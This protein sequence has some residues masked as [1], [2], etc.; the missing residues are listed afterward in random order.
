M[1]KLSVSNYQANKPPPLLNIDLIGGKRLQS[2]RRGQVRKTSKKS[3]IESFRGYSLPPIDKS[4]FNTVKTLN[5]TLQ[6]QLSQYATNLKTVL[7]DYQVGMNNVKNCYSTCKSNYSGQ[8]SDIQTLEQQDNALD[9]Q[10]ACIAGCN[11]SKV[12]LWQT[13][14]AASYAGTDGTTDTFSSCAA[15][16]KDGPEYCRGF[17]P[18][19]YCCDEWDDYGYGYGCNGYYGDY[20]E[21]YLEGSC[22]CKNG[23]TKA[24][25]YCGHQPFTCN[26]VCQPGGKPYNPNAPPQSPPVPTPPP[27][28]GFPHG[29]YKNGPGMCSNIDSV[30]NNT[31][32]NCAVNAAASQKG[33]YWIPPSDVGSTAPNVDVG[34]YPDGLCNISSGTCSVGGGYFNCY[35]TNFIGGTSATN[36]IGPNCSTASSTVLGAVAYTYNANAPPSSGAP[37]SQNKPLC[38][39]AGTE[40]TCM[41]NWNGGTPVKCMG[42]GKVACAS[43]D[44]ANCFWGTCG[45]N[46]A[47]TAYPDRSNWRSGGSN[48]MII[49]CGTTGAWIRSDG[50]STCEILSGGN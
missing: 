19:N 39:T 38:E 31:L 9:N 24:T 25:V 14:P 49:N 8:N 2:K 3:V 26:E 4:E 6:G 36:N 28:G 20:G 48:P 11:L 32:S 12:Y 43:N 47:I 30:T 37:W 42:N 10:S 18:T 41:A 45:T 40:F 16:E 27:P 23:E 21:S 13:T 15:L 46:G 33:F 34:S 44:G 1:N 35:D 22:V 50:K 5:K 7:S 29:I 17:Y